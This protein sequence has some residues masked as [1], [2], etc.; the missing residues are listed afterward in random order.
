VRRDAKQVGRDAWR[1]SEQ[2]AQR[3]RRGVAE[4]V[5]GHPHECRLDVL[6]V[7]RTQ[8]RQAREDQLLRRL[9][10][11]VEAADDDQREDDL[12]V[13]RLLVGTAQALGDAPGKR[14][15][16]LDVGQGVVAVGTGAF[17]LPVAV[18]RAASTSG[19]ASLAAASLQSL[20][21]AGATDLAGGLGARCAARLPVNL[22][23]G[24]AP[25]DP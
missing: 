14:G 16:V 6:D 3:E 2:P 12:A 23:Q 7:L 10:R 17:C 15:V 24:V 13:V 9:Q 20:G 11:L 21:F 8:L 25:P 5:A 19:G 4:L 1:V 22:R 18:G